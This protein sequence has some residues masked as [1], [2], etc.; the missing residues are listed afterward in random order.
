[1]LDLPELFRRHPEA[2]LAK[3]PPERLLPIRSGTK[4][5]RALY[6]FDADGVLQLALTAYRNYR[7]CTG[8][9][10]AE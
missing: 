5:P 2:M 9:D 7:G 4:E 6:Y 8:T 10:R 1:L 3:V